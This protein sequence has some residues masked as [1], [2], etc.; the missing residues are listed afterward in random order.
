MEPAP[1]DLYERQDF[2][3]KALMTSFAEMLDLPPDTFRQFFE[4]EGPQG[5]EGLEG[6]QGY[7]R[8]PHGWLMSLAVQSW[9]RLIEVYFS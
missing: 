9:S 7:S 6:P 2:L 4:G 1:Q 8:D 5:P 3:G